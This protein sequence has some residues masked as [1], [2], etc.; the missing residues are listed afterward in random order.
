MYAYPYS[1]AVITLFKGV[2]YETNEDT[3]KQVINY[4][5]DIKK[6]F[7]VIGLNLYIDK[8]EGYAFL[9]Q[10]EPDD[11]EAQNNLRLIERRQLSYPVTLLCVLLRK[12]LLE[13]DV[14]GGDT[15]V[16]LEK[17]QIR[18]M[19][20]IFLP[21]TSNEAKTSDKIDEYINKVVDYG[22]LRKIKNE[23]NQYEINRIL[24][25]KISADTL[26]DIE[27]VLREYANSLN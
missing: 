8:T 12:R 18:D 7:D 14:A 15:R 3:W 27:Q 5:T 2:V 25:A 22:F 11:E 24:K 26:Q 13:A 16:V 20:K 9:R 1:P 17:D 10:N 23:Q 19:L 21:E 4:E 6:Y